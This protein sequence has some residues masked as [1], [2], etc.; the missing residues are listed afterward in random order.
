MQHKAAES[1]LDLVL[2]EIFQI[3][4]H[5]H[6][7]Y[8]YGKPNLL[9][10]PPQHLVVDHAPKQKRVE[11]SPLEIRHAVEAGAILAKEME[12]TNSMDNLC[13]SLIQ[14]CA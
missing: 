9:T 3:P 5:N 1:N 13:I 8:Q 10:T 7:P 6:A 4:Y 14:G 11:F 2:R 12:G